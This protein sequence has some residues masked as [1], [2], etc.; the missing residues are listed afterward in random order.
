[1]RASERG[2]WVVA[3]N[4]LRIA[5][6]VAIAVYGFFMALFPR[7]YSIPFMNLVYRPAL[8]PSANQGLG[9]ILIIVGAYLFIRRPLRKV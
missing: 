6:G 3:G 1:M 8:P 4:E 2:S 7:Q 5:V 9:L